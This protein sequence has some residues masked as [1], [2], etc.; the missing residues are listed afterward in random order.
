[1][2]SSHLNLLLHN[3]VYFVL[4]TGSHVYNVS[5]VLSNESCNAYILISCRP[6]SLRLAREN[7]CRL[8][9]HAVVSTAH[10]QLHN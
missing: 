3:Y 7:A 6:I 1:M 9:T 10:A 4:I 2:A 8:L 5:V